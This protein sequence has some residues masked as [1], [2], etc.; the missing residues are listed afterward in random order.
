MLCCVPQQDTE[1]WK[2]LR[3]SFNGISASNLGSILGFGSKSR[4]EEWKY[5]RKLKES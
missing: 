3:G 5:Y 1:L 2:E 4:N